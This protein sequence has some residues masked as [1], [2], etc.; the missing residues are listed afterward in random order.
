MGLFFY[1]FF[2]AGPSITF[3]DNSNS[4]EDIIVLSPSN[5]QL[6]DTINRHNDVER[7]DFD[8]LESE[9]S[10]DIL[11][12]SD[13]DDLSE[14]FLNNE[15]GNQHH[16]LFADSFH[17]VS[18]SSSS[19]STETIRAIN[20]HSSEIAS[21]S[22][23][24]HTAS[25]SESS[26]CE[27]IQVTPKKSPEYILLSSDS[28]QIVKRKRTLSDTSSSSSMSDLDENKPTTSRNAERKYNK[29][30]KKAKKKSKKVKKHKKKS[31]SGSDTE[32]KSKKT[33]KTK[34]NQRPISQFSNSGNSNDRIT[35]SPEGPGSKAYDM[36][37]M[38]WSTDD[39]FL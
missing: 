23:N 36:A 17:L 26:F 13:A 9:S 6:I 22:R 32:Y 25:G 7:L 19:S 1:L 2:L 27:E 24:A 10:S 21:G 31:S 33:L 20:I 38:G 39:D 16:H 18:S 8:D 11:G 5:T 15:T 29:K 3:N 35:S 34:S 28:E 30:K 14:Y 37:M 4:E 12:N